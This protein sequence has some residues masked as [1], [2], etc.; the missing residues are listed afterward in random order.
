MTHA[1]ISGRALTSNPL[2]LTSALTLTIVT[3]WLVYRLDSTSEWSLP[4]W[5]VLALIIYPGTLAHYSVMLLPVL[6]L[7]WKEREKTPLGVPG[8]ALVV[9]LIIGLAGFHSNA[10]AAYMVAWTVLASLA[11]WTISLEHRSQRVASF[12]PV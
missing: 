10:F 8:S 2:F 6:L 12:S 1:S 4:L 7:I 3:A 9:S 11:L 5:L